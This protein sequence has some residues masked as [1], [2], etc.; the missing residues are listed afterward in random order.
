MQHIR[1]DLL[2]SRSRCRQ[3]HTRSAGRVGNPIGQSRARSRRAD[4]SGILEG[5]NAAL[6]SVGHMLLGLITL[7]L[8]LSLSLM[9]I[10]TVGNYTPPTLHDQH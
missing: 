2:N 1:P 3:L 10:R 4:E 7:P 9:K 8:G 6:S 5:L